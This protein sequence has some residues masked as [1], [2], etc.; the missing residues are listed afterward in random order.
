MHV[1]DLEDAAAVAALPIGDDDV[2]HHVAARQFHEPV[3]K[4]DRDAWFAAVNVAGTERLLGRM[5]EVGC[6]RL[7][8]FSTDMVYGVPE[9]VPVPPDHPRRPL[10][11]YGG[12]KAGGG[13]VRRISRKGLAITVFRPRLIVGPGRL[14]VLAKLFTLIER[15]WPVPLIGDGRNHYQMISVF[16]CVGAVEAALAKGVP[17]GAYNLGS[18][19]P[20]SVREL[21][22]SV[23]AA[24]G[25]RSVLVPTPAAPL[26]ALLSALDAA[27]AHLAP[28]RA[29]QDC[30]PKLSGRCQP[31]HGGPRLAAPPQRRRHAG[32]GLRG[33]PWRSRHG[34]VWTLVSCP[35]DNVT[36]QWRQTETCGPPAG[37]PTFTQAIEAGVG[38]AFGQGSA[39][40]RRRS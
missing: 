28:P 22:A 1:A 37:L 19:E 27:G 13:S 5:V 39:E 31:D 12:S 30:G 3:P 29:V 23:I 16:D 4:S 32:R 17:N 14:G 36:S 2:V 35:R 26:K 34:A 9:R 11:P 21:L 8:F 24:A 25:S 15:G 33:V 20:P 6:R 38:E 7:I 40:R 10:G 18:T